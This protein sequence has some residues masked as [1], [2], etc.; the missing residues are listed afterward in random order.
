MTLLKNAVLAVLLTSSATLAHAQLAVFDGAAAGNWIQQ[1]RAA[2][3]QISELKNQY[4][5]A[6]QAYEAISGA[7][8]IGNIL[9][10][11]LLDQYMPAEYAPVLSAIRSGREASIPGLT[12]QILDLVAREQ[13]VS[14]AAQFPEQAQARAN[15]DALWRQYA[16][17]K[18]IQ[19][20]HYKRAGTNLSSMEQMLDKL[21]SNPDPKAAQDFNSRLSLESLKLQNTQIQLATMKQMQDEQEKM[22]RQAAADQERQSFRDAIGQLQNNTKRTATK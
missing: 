4:S 22:Q 2:R 13:K 10:N 7:R 16:G 17:V 3:D 15:C 12:K 19:E 5:Q 11:Q 20:Q 8:D 21:V 6:K 9:R 1:I 18:I 14:C